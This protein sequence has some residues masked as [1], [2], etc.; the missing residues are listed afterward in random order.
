MEHGPIQNELHKV[1]KLNPNLLFNESTKIADFS[2][3]WELQIE[4]IPSVASSS[5]LP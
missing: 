4:T 3:R 2:S 5:L 1:W